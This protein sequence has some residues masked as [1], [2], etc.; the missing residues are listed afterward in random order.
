MKKNKGTVFIE[1]INNLNGH[2]STYIV[3]GGEKGLKKKL[4]LIT[5]LLS[6]CC[7]LPRIPLS[8]FDIK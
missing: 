3:T 1:H 4:A 8:I 6:V 7:L 5:C 2:S